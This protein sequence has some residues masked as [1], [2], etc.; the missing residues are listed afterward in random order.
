MPSNECVATLHVDESTD[1]FFK[2]QRKTMFEK[3]KRCYS[4]MLKILHCQKTRLPYQGTHGS[5]TNLIKNLLSARWCFWDDNRLPT[6]NVKIGCGGWQ[7]LSLSCAFFSTTR[8]VVFNQDHQ[9]GD[10]ESKSVGLLGILRNA[11][12]ATLICRCV[13]SL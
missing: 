1:F 4:T 9:T 7:K 5:M 10:G 3:C 11:H 8:L 12:C 13:W 6:K 2:K